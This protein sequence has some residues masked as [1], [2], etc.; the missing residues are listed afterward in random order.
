MTATAMTRRDKQRVAN[1][2]GIL[3]AALAIAE[4]EGW[5]AVTIRK[6]ADEIDYT[7]PIIYQHF[8]NKEAALQ[9]LM[10]RG[11][12]LL[13]EAMRHPAPAATPDEH[14]LN[15]GRAYLHFVEKQP[16]LYE[17]MSGLSGVSL[18]SGVRGRAA[19]GVTELVVGAVAEWAAR[20]GVTVAD[21]LAACETCWG[22]L[23][24]M[25]CLGMLPDVGFGRA[26]R[27]AADALS[28]LMK[29]WEV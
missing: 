14:L 5:P 17:L 24:G 23:H 29:S 20:K 6:I 11:Y 27:H 28:A 7:S 10:E 19:A 22:V 1:R 4:R 13:S 25:A 15:M 21:P 12:D 8:D 2:E 26:E 18:D 9:V 16:R 3:R